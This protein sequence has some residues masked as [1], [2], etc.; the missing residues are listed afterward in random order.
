[1]LILDVAYRSPLLGPE[2]CQLQEERKCEAMLAE[3]LAR[4][5]SGVAGGGEEDSWW[6]CIE[7]LLFCDWRPELAPS[8]LLCNENVQPGVNVDE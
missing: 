3:S 2:N 5:T 4:K 1:M 8:K 7:V 6:P